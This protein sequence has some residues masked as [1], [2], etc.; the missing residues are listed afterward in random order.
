MA[1]HKEVIN[2]DFLSCHWG[3]IHHP[4]SRAFP[5]EML[6]KAVHS[7]ADAGQSKHVAVKDETYLTPLQGHIVPISQEGCATLRILALKVPDTQQAESHRA[8]AREGIRLFLAFSEPEWNIGVCQG[9]LTAR[10][11]IQ[12]DSSAFR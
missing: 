11:A 3:Q 7:F 10:G 1:S 12:T 9:W 2:T 8:M 6:G 5:A 4:N